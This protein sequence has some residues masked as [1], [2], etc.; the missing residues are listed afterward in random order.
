MSG[1]AVSRKKSEYRSQGD[2][3]DVHESVAA[4]REIP[5]P[6]KKMETELKELANVSH[7]Q[8]KPGLM[9][10]LFLWVWL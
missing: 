6:C 1:R 8:G 5:L 4:C 2:E 7:K 3:R 9:C 10:G